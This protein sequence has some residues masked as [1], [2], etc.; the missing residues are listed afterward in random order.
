MSPDFTK[1][2]VLLCPG[3][4]RPAA[5]VHYVNFNLAAGAYMKLALALRG[6]NHHSTA[7]TDTYIY[8]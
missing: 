5:L 2:Q 3:E 7:H 8:I 4:R 6:P 1:C